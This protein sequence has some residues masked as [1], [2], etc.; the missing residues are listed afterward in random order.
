VL[1]RHRVEGDEVVLCLGEKGRHL[2]CRAFQAHDHIA[3]DPPGLLARGGLK[4]LP[5][6][7]ADHPL[8]ATVNMAAHLAQEVDGASLPG[9]AEDLADR[10][11]QALVLIGDHQLDAMQAA[12]HQRSEELPPEGPGLGRA[13]IERDHL[14]VAGLVDRIGDHQ[15][16][17]AHPPVGIAHLLH[18]GVEPQV[19][20]AALQRPLAEGH[21]LLVEGGAHAR[22]G[23]LGHAGDPELLDHALDL[24]RRHAVDVALHHDRHQR[25]LGA[26]TRLQEAREVRAGAELRDEQ[27][28]RAGARVPPTLAVAV[29]LA[30]PLGGSPYSEARAD[31]GGDLGLHDLVAEEAHRLAYEV[32]VVVGEHLANELVG[33][34]VV[35]VGHRDCS[36][37]DWLWRTNGS[38][39][40]VAGPAFSRSPLL[41]HY[42]GRDRSTGRDP[43]AYAS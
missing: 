26:G 42:P 24:S 28:E 18:L 19:G 25:L 8:L 14:A 35:G 22:D 7:R 20:V 21:H 37:S 27:L 10:R 1:G 2:G 40:A 38:E 15:R 13:D 31:L 9:A 43:C 6:R 3:A 11:F 33:A 36:F 4:D 17:A 34:Q 32:G 39:L 12:G 23:R 29:S 5:E 30:R 41:H 16:L